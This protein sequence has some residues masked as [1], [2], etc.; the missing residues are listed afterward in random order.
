[1][2]PGRVALFDAENGPKLMIRRF[3]MIGGPYIPVSLVDVGGL[4]VLKDI[5][6]LKQTVRELEARFVVF[7]SLRMLSSGAK[8]NDGDVMEPIMTALKLLARETELRRAAGSITAA[9]P[10][11]ATTAARR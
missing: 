11:R 3:R 2:R 10:S 4:H 7:D 8:E 1:M 6:W 9:S 5:D